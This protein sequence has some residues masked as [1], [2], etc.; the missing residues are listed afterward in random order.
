MSLTIGTQ[1]GSHEITALLG[2]GGMGEVYRA[3]DTKLGRSVAVKVLPEAF[4]QN[5]DWIARFEREAKVLASL[6]H[7]NIATLYGMEES[8]GKHFL[9]MELVEGETLAESLKRGPIAVEEALQIALQILEALE[10]AHEKGIVHRDLKPANIKITPDGKAKVLDF[11]LAKAMSGTDAGH[12]DATFSNSPTLSMAAT[13]AGVILGTAAYMSPEQAKGAEADARSDAFSFGCVFYEMLTGRQPFQGESVSEILAAVLIREADFSGLPPNLNPRIPEVLKR[14][15]E[16]SPKRRWHAIAD[17]RNEFGMLAAAPRVQPAVVT[18]AQH[19]PLWKRALPVVAAVVIFS[20]LAGLA[21]WKLKPPAPGMVTRFPLVLPEGHTFLR[22]PRNVIAISP[23]GSKLA[24]VAGQLYLRSM[25]N[26]DAQPL[27]GA[28]NDVGNPFFSPDGQWIAFYSFTDGALKKIAVTGGA[29]VMICKSCSPLGASWDGDQIV[30]GR[31]ENGGGIMRVSANG[32][33]PEPLVKIKV[34]EGTAQTPQI[35]DHGR[36]VLFSLAPP[37]GPERWD[38]AQIVVQSI[39]SGERKVVVRGGSAGRYVS[40]GHIVYALGENLLAVP[41]DLRTLETK[42]GG[43]VSLVEGVMRPIGARTAAA[44]FAISDNGTLAYV[45]ST[46]GGFTARAAL[47][48]ADRTG[49][50]E[51]LPLSPAAYEYPRVSPDGKQLAV[52]ITEGKDQAVWVDSISQNSAPRRLTFGGNNIIPVWSRDGRYLYF[53]SD[54]DGKVGI[55]RQLADGTGSAE[56]L[57]TADQLD[58]ATAPSSV[59]PLDKLLAFEFRITGGGGNSDIWLLPLE[60]DRKPKS[61]IEMPKFQSHASFSPDGRWIAYMSNELNDARPQIFVR[62]Y[63]IT[64]S[65][66]QITSEGCG[67]P[68]WSPDGNE[69]F[70]FFGTRLFAVKI[71]KAPVFSAEKPEPLPVIGLIQQIGNPRNYDVTPDGRFLTVVPV[72]QTETNKPP[73]QQINIVLNW[74]TE[75]QQRVPVK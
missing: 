6:N 35:L 20:T 26:M 68:V 18:P 69:I 29:P 8:S 2:K 3:R 53:R 63:P 32:G 66:Y 11:G 1:L 30:F 36:A 34:E 56:R 75:L 74:F 31:A 43:P 65:K 46:G 50:T 27:P 61:L 33:E 4:A 44:H 13:Q 16:K 59:D 21:G 45:I 70:C 67:E 52:G 51:K 72:S 73:V 48:L 54:R 9:V 60:G 24:Y 5:A 15:L 47:A 62:S 37:G 23:D 12:A 40:T 64:E 14:C 55:F 42:S 57:M 7:P 49:K 71:R 28:G 58:A 25:S 38:E 17:L 19:A 22:T 39:S 10:A 41:F